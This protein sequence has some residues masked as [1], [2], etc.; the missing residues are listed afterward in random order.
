MRAYR[1][2]RFVGYEP[3][4]MFLLTRD[5]YPI[6]VYPREYQRRVFSGDKFSQTIQV[7]NAIML[8][9]NLKLKWMFGDSASG[10]IDV[11]LKAGES[12]TYPLVFSLPKVDKRLDAKLTLTLLENG[13]PFPRTGKWESLYSVI[14]RRRLSG[15][16]GISGVSEAV[17]GMLKDFGLKTVVVS[18]PADLEK[19]ALVVTSGK[20][21]E[22]F[23]GAVDGWI[24]GGGNVVVLEQAEEFDGVALYLNKFS[25]TKT[26]LCAPGNP[27]MKGVQKQDL[28]YWGGDNY[29][30]HRSY[31][32]PL[33]GDFQ[34]LCQTGDINGLR[35]TPFVELGRGL[36]R[37]VCCSL[38]L[39]QKYREEPIVGIL[40]ENILSVAESHPNRKLPKVGA[41]L[42]DLM[43]KRLAGFGYVVEDL[44]AIENVTLSDYPVVWIDAGMA[45]VDVAGLKSYVENGGTLI[46]SRLDP[47]VDESFAEL[48]PFKFM[49]S[50]F[51]RGIA[52]GGEMKMTTPSP[53]TNG[54]SHFDL[55]WKRGLWRRFGPMVHI[56]SVP[57]EFSFRK[58]SRDK[59]EVTELLGPGALCEARL[60]K[61]RLII[62]QIRWQESFDREERSVRLF[63]A[64]MY[65]LR[66]PR[67]GSGAAKKTA[68]VASVSIPANKL[69]KA[70]ILTGVSDKASA[71]PKGAIVFRGAQ[72]KTPESGPNVLVLG[73]P[74]TLPGMP[75][76]KT[77]PVGKKADTLLLWQ[78]AAFGFIDYDES[79]P[80]IKYT[81]HYRNGSKKFTRTFSV[82]YGID[83]YE[84]LG[85]QV[86]SLTGATQV[87]RWEDVGISSYLMRW[88]NPEPD[89]VIESLD[90]ETT[91]EKVAAMVFGISCE[92]RAKK[93]YKV[94]ARRAKGM[95]SAG[96]ERY[97]EIGDNGRVWALLMCFDNI[98][99][100]RGGFDKVWPPE[101]KLDLSAEYRGM[102]RKVIKWK[103]HVEPIVKKKATRS[104]IQ[105][106]QFFDFKAINDH[107]FYTGFAYTRIKAPE[108]KKVILAFGSDD[109]SKLWINGK[110]IRDE[111]VAR[112][113]FLGQDMFVI[114]LKKGWNDVFIKVVNCFMEGGFAFDLKEYKE[115][116]IEDWKRDWRTLAPRPSLEYEY[117][118]FYDGKQKNP[119][120]G[121]KTSQKK[122]IARIM[123]ARIEGSIHNVA[124]VTK[125]PTAVTATDDGIRV[126]FHKGAGAGISLNIPQLGGG[127]KVF[128]NGSFHM[129][130]MA[131]KG[132]SAQN[133]FM[134]SRNLGGA[135]VGDIHVLMQGGVPSKEF[136]GDGKKKPKTCDTIKISLQCDLGE[137]RTTYTK[138]PGGIAE[139][140]WHTLEFIW[141]DKGKMP[142]FHMFLDK[143]KI[144]SIEDYTGPAFNLKNSMQVVQDAYRQGQ[145][146]IIIKDLL[147]T[148]NKKIPAI[149]N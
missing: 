44:A 31:S 133:I 80:V 100:K 79:K 54:F 33:E 21:F 115:E 90:L 147:L 89:A 134:A 109:G 61:G 103:K 131:P 1:E 111:W 135:N 20:L 10:V 60:G 78:A 50:K 64:L 76:K 4:D 108:A 52:W 47:S 75:R 3:F 125:H 129:S 28:F 43:V 149:K 97:T 32:S 58:H 128:A 67:S 5:F 88:K 66:I 13:K 84:F 45:K 138:V 87:T 17:E 23:S 71:F 107:Q 124:G 81:V 55:F 104:L 59:Y 72:F 116:Y 148:E 86:E 46:L 91:H 37:V 96:K 7:H 73:A 136:G 118:A 98:P 99:P 34:V 83:V 6:D 142:G 95:W 145:G 139:G 27:L 63:N 35:M 9:K 105:L 126:D 62:D 30:S 121:A 110:L 11:R 74:K 57:V 38:L 29:V 112:G 40:L 123:T 14:P 25:N 22:N 127:D 53:L 94:A 106:D 122:T 2:Q 65:N 113:C 101:K 49:L 41:L 92:T 137:A 68:A 119:R 82:R 146:A 48:I 36:G 19:C 16:V 70:G 24:R 12:R 140:V 18:T 77:I 39:A 130:F 26:H 15:T 42:S 56:T 93:T 120:Q 141:G 51:P 144:F 85:G 143:R 8:P 132:C 69:T 117:D 102:Y 114:D